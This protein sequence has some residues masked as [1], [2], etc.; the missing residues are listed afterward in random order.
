MSMTDTEAAEFDLSPDPRIL[1]M[2][3][4]INLAQWQA[5]AELVDN[6]VD[7]FLVAPELTTTPRVTVNLPSSDTSNARVTVRDNGPGMSPEVLEKAVRAGWSGSTSPGTLGM[8]GMGFNIATAR[9]GTVTTVWTTT[10]HDREWH[11][12]EINFDELA[13]QRHYRTSHLTRAKMDPEECGTEVTITRLKPEQR[14]WLAKPTNRS[15]ARKRLSEIYSAMLRPDGRPIHFELSVDNHPLQAKNHCVWSGEREVVGPRGQAVP[16]MI[17]VDTKLPNRPYCMACWQWL[18]TPTEN[19]ACPT[20]GEVDSVVERER[21]V[22]GWIGLQRYLST[23]NFGIDF[24]RNG[25]KIETGNKDLFA[26]TG[27]DGTEPE[28]PIDDPRNR[29]RFVGEIHLDHC[30]VTYMKDRFERTDPAWEE[31]TRIVR[32]DGPLRPKK[33]EEAGFGPNESPLFRLYQVF[34]RSTPHGS[35]DVAGQ[36]A[37]VLVV[38]DNDRA[39][40]MARHFDS[41]ASKYEPD[42]E[43]WKLIEEEDD[44]LLTPDSEAPA[45]GNLAGFAGNGLAE[46]PSKAANEPSEASPSPPRHAIASL[47]REYVHDGTEQRWN[48]RAF[49]VNRTD[50]DLDPAGTPWRLRRSPSGEDDFFVDINHPIFKSATMTELDALLSQL[51]WSASDFVRGGAEAAPFALVL[52]DLRQRYGRVLELDP[53]EIKARADGVIA[54]IARTWARSVAED[55]CLTLFQEELTVAQQ[56]AI[57]GAMAI[58]SVSRPDTAVTEGRFLEFAAPYVVLKFVEEHPE[59]F[60][61]GRCWDEPYSTLSYPTDTTT[62]EARERVRRRYVALLSDAVWLAE[63]EPDDL[64]VASR[65]RLLRASLAVDLLAPVAEDDDQIT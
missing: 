31:M 9:L 41:G 11:G 50:P 56:E 23:S 61:D 29:G 6:A 21:R 34:R 38:R 35:G 1:P 24:I 42:E 32:G 60:F 44:R 7:G 64:A 10:R 20:C 25:R 13:R 63:H 55:D 65:E 45:A 39:E 52:A 18:P 8:F 48:I 58:R 62:D 4:E 2:L 17:L 37:R 54:R 26:W 51:A 46:A 16:A 40:E 27:E 14:A 19:L 53:V 3:G 28:Y 59:L 36:W 30:R 33:A 49:R 22:H 47:T 12:L 15:R 5:L 57:Y 43:W